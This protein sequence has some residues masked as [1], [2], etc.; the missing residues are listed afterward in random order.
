MT[1]IAPRSDRGFTLLEGIFAMFL[2]AVAA[3]ALTEALNTIGLASFEG[4]QAAQVESIVR[5]YLTEA[6]RAPEL[7]TGER[8]FEL[9]DGLTNVR[10]FVEELDLTSRNGETLTDMLRIEVTAFRN[11]YGREKILGSAETWRYNLLY[12]ANSQPAPPSIPAAT[13]DPAAAGQVQ[14]QPST[15]P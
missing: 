3:V 10:V 15:T 14:P 6:S 13:G 9:E 1:P 12:Q 8:V 11:E 5:T 7:E 2:F 4:Q